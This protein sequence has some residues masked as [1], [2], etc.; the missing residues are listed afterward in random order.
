MTLEA[1]TVLFLILLF[2][3]AEIGRFMRGIRGRI[4]SVN[5]TGF[6]QAILPVVRVRV[7]LNNGPEITAGLNGCAACLGRLKIGDEV[8][9]CETSDGYTI[10]LP[11]FTAKHCRQ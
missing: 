2:L 11:W 5:E 8:R 6:A 4:V 9:V 7:K 3:A 1:I 10:D